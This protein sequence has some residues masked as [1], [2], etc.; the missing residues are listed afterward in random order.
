MKRSTLIAFIVGLVIGIG[1]LFWTY[2]LTK[3]KATVIRMDNPL[4]QSISPE[5]GICLYETKSD[6]K[7]YEPPY[8]QKF[9]GVPFSSGSYGKD[10]RIDATPFLLVNVAIWALGLP[11]AVKASGVLSKKLRHK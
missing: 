8:K 9:R 4:C 5:C 6:G 11:L 10:S 7:C 2:E 3:Q 1:Q